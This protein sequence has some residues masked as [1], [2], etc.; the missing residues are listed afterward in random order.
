MCQNEPLNDCKINFR[1]V[2]YTCMYIVYSLHVFFM[3]R[4][5]NEIIAGEMT[6]ISAIYLL[7]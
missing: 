1:Y 3:A 7:F 2:L 5:L 6:A 4:E